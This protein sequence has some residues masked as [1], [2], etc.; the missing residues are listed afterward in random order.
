[1]LIFFINTSRTKPHQGRKPWIKESGWQA[2]REP[3]RA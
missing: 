2:E 1:L 3:L